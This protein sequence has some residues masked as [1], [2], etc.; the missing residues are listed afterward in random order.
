[1]IDQAIKLKYVGSTHSGS[2]KPTKFICLAFKM[3]QM[4]IPKEI[5]IQFLQAKDYK[6]LTALG[7]FYLRLVMK[8]PEVYQILEPFYNDN[9]KLRVRDTAGAFSILYVDEFVDRLLRNDIVLDVILPRIQKRSILE[10]QGILD[11]RVSV[12]V[13]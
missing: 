3:L 6:Y 10:D 2:R 5:A 8:P 12:L 4:N 9:R 11:P 13:E 1:M 7:I